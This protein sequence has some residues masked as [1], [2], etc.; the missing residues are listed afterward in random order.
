MLLGVLESTT[1]KS[2]RRPILELPHPLPQVWPETLIF[3]SWGWVL[4][5]KVIW[6][7]LPATIHKGGRG[8]EFKKKMHL[9]WYTN[10]IQNINQIIVFSQTQTGANNCSQNQADLLE[11][12]SHRLHLLHPAP[13][14]TRSQLKSHKHFWQLWY[15]SFNLLVVYSCQLTYSF[16]T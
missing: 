7:K 1:P 2:E 9:K 12:S 6:I 11:Y 10:K 16:N 3:L 14:F 13:G 8:G 4:N 5:H 15:N